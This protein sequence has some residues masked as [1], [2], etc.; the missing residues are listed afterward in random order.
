MVA[1]LL[2]FV[3]MDDDCVKQTVLQHVA[4]ANMMP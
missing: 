1:R 4:D 2:F 3:L